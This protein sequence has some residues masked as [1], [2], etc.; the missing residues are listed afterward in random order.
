MVVQHPREF[1]AF[2]SCQPPFLRRPPQ[3]ATTGAK[4][5][6]PRQNPLLLES[7]FQGEG[8][9]G[10]QTISRGAPP[11][12]W[13]LRNPRRPGDRPLGISSKDP[14]NNLPEI[15]GALRPAP[16]PA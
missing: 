2:F 9:I 1:L 14:P 10:P 15:K 5:I 13:N 8:R 6:L 7:F 4:K 16:I 3:T 11:T 12:L